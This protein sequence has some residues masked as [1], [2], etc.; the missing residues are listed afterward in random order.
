MSDPC[1][2]I[3][4]HLGG[5]SKMSSL[6]VH[7][8]MCNKDYSLWYV[9]WFCIVK[10][11]VFSLRRPEAILCH[12]T[13]VTV[14]VTVTGKLL[15]HTM[16]QT[17]WRICSLPLSPTLARFFASFMSPTT[18]QL[19]DLTTNTDYDTLTMT[20]VTPLLPICNSCRLWPCAQ[21]EAI[22]ETAG[23][24]KI[25]MVIFWADGR[26]SHPQIVPYWSSSV[27]CHELQHGMPG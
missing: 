3:L 25:S 24:L 4:S 22:L 5:D 12:T 17:T 15:S 6:I 19:P 9:R 11:F 20:S 1:C 8:S 7:C 23:L 16:P 21:S 27:S 14:T 10:I 26:R 18:K 13:M 2:D